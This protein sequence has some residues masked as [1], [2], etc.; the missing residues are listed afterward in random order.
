MDQIFKLLYQ[1]LRDQT[2][3][4]L[5]QSLQSEAPSNPA[6]SEGSADLADVDHPIEDTHSDSEKLNQNSTQTWITLVLEDSRWQLRLSPDLENTWQGSTALLLAQV[7][8]G[9]IKS[10]LD[11]ISTRT[12]TKN[13][14]EK[15]WPSP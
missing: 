8:L 5:I 3:L 14:S 9:G 10:H 4:D 2:G 11:P 7:L 1:H 13:A 12:L 15:H 6:G